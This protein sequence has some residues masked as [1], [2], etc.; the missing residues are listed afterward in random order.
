M[1]L[2]FVYYQ[3]ELKVGLLP[4]VKYK[5]LIN[6]LEDILIFQNI[7]V[8]KDFFILTVSEPT[9]HSIWFGCGLFRINTIESLWNNI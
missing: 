9:N 5:V 8:L 2:L 1:I 6:E 7:K 4:I 3:I